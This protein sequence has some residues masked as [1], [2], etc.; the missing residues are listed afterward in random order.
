[1]FLHKKFL[2]IF[3]YK[4]DDD[5]EYTEPDATPLRVFDSLDMHNVRTLHAFLEFCKNYYDTF[6]DESFPTFAQ[7][8]FC[9]YERKE[10]DYYEYLKYRR[11]MFTTTSDG[12]MSVDTQKNVLYDLFLMNC[13]YYN[14]KLNNG[15]EFRGS[16]FDKTYEFQNRQYIKCTT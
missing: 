7:S 13:C 5:E 6:T 9:P 15:E 3:T 8:P 1:M 12:N 11:N 14:I 10:T 16:P 2:N 4:M